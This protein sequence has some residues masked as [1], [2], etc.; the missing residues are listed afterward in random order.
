MRV[1]SVSFL[2]TVLCLGC[3][4][5]DEARRKAVEKNLNQLSEAIKNYEQNREPSVSEF[6]HIISCETDYYTTGPQQNRPPDGTYPAGTRVNIV[7]DAGSYVLVRSE[8]TIEAYVTAQH[9]KKQ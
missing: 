1:F 5:A 6:T 4:S 8:D 3:N 7:E 9:V 2:A